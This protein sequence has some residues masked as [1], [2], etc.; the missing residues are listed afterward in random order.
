MSQ[1]GEDNPAGPV[2][3]VR[4]TDVLPE[5]TQTRQRAQNTVDRVSESS[6]SEN[7]EREP[8]LSRRTQHSSNESSSAQ[9][10]ELKY[11]AEAVINLFIPVTACMIFVI[12][13]VQCLSSYSGQQKQTV[14]FI[15]TPFHPADDDSAGTIIWQTVANSLIMISVIAVMTFVLVLLYKYECNML[16]GGWLIFSTMTLIF[17]FGYFYLQQ[18]LKVNNAALDWVTLGIVM[19]NFGIVGIICI[20]WKGPLF[21][22]QCYLIISAALMALIFIKMLPNW[23]TWLILAFLSIWDLIAVLCP[24]GPLN[25]LLQLANDRE[26]ELFPA[27]IYRFILQL[28]KSSHMIILSSGAGIAVPTVMVTTSAGT[29]L[30]PLLGMAETSDPSPQEEVQVRQPRSQRSS[31]RTR[32]DERREGVKLG[33]GDFIFYSVLV[34]KAS[35]LHDWNITLA[36]IL[37]IL[38]GL[39]TTLIILAFFKKPLPALPISLTLGLIFYFTTTYVIAPFMDLCIMK[40]VF[41]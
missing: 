39:S 28:Y 5:Q 35:Q 10:T 37:S 16:L 32:T 13:S 30:A 23:T 15:Y 1:R 12:A 22:Q 3:P 33:L 18:I 31:E 7:A 2:G 11:G 26:D 14:S 27:L 40:Q 25:M 24:Y 4:R 8:I 20:H 17:M 6:T 9:D 34:G 21:L 29:F 38:V 19:W 36:C 41:L